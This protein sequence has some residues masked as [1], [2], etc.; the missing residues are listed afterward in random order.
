LDFD[1]SKAG[2]QFVEDTSWLGGG[3]DYRLGVDGISV[4][5]VLLTA[6]L[7]PLCIFATLCSANGFPNAA[8]Y[9]CE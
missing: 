5:F 4:L 7:T 2:F 8:L 9:L 6:F 1:S 3:I